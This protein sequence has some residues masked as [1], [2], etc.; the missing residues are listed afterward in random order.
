M[1]LPT[2][3]SPKHL[4]EVSSVSLQDAGFDLIQFSLDWRSHFS[5]GDTVASF[6][7]RL[8]TDTVVDHGQCLPISGRVPVASQAH[9][10][11]RGAAVEA[12]PG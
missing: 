4:P 8:V 12:M 10:L 3:G 1:F 9:F 5:C 2:E 6:F 11:L 7:Q